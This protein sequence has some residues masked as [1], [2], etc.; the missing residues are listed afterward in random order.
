MVLFIRVTVGTLD[1]RLNID[2]E[3]E[4]ESGVLHHLPKIYLLYRW[5]FQTANR[6]I[7]TQ[8]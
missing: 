7:S 1:L 8:L 5:K 3:T 6:K 4:E 2:A